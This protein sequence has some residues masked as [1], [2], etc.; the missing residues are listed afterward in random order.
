M[1]GPRTERAQALHLFPGAVVTKNH[2]LGGFSNRNVLSHSSGGSKSEIKA[3]RVG[4]FGGLCPGLLNGCLLLVS[5][6]WLPSVCV[7]FKF[8]LLIGTSVIWVYGPP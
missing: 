5:S 7:V 6:H 8:H 2:R 4:F 1:W 3:C